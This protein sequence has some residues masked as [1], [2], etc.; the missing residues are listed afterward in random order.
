V[1]P[2]D[3]H[4]C[5]AAFVTTPT[6]QVSASVASLDQ[7]A[8]LDKH[9]GQRNL[10]LVA[11]GAR[12]LT[13]GGGSYQIDPQILMIDFWNAER[14]ALDVDLVF[15]HRGFPGRL[16]VLLPDLPEVK[17]PADSLRGFKAAS[18]RSLSPASRAEL[19]AWFGRIDDINSR[20]QDGSKTEGNG[21]HDPDDSP[22]SG[23]DM[24]RLGKISR[25]NRARIFVA[26]QKAMP[27]FAGIKIHPERSITAA[28]V[29][30]VPSEAKPG[31]RFRFDVLQKHGE[32]LIG[33]STYFVAV[34]KRARHGPRSSGPR[35]LAAQRRQKRER[36]R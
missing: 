28:L 21:W 26:D 17:Q 20:L 31:D 23:H 19:K 9:I 24:R 27:T 15:D 14:E 22:L 4:V 1:L 16:A 10:H 29:V 34:M 33:G 13:Q 12:P 3:E 18:A 25:L 30:E 35:P 8:M 36:V 11:A 2:G 5:A 32:N 7:A 6:D